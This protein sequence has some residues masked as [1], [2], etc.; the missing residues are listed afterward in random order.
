[1]HTLHVHL[2]TLPYHLHKRLNYCYTHTQVVNTIP[3]IRP[4]R[5]HN[6]PPT[7]NHTGLCQRLY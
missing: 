6:P 5:I 3:L 7:L 4:K 2:T 1:M